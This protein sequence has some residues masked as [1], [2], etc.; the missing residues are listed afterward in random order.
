MAIVGLI[1]FVA[2]VVGLDAV[3]KPDLTGTAL[4]LVGVLLAIIPAVLWLVFFYL[5]DRLEP[6]PKTGVPRAGVAV[7]GHGPPGAGFVLYRRGD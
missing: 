4:I 7:P 2:V 5:Q 3:L 6:E 1:V